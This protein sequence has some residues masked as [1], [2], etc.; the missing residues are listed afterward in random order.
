LQLEAGFLLSKEVQAVLFE[1]SDLHEA[2]SR[3]SQKE[4]G[5]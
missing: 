1:I 3:V 2:L 4:A 5:R